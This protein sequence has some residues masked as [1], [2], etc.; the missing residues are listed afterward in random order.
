MNRT[1]LALALVTV[2][3][4]A[5]AEVED[6]LLRIDGA[7]VRVRRAQGWEAIALAERESRALGAAGGVLP[8]YKGE[9][10]GWRIVAATDGTRS[11]ALQ[12]RG[13]GAGT[14]VLLS[15]VDLAPPRVPARPALW[16][17]PGAR[18]LR[19]VEQDGP[20]PSRQWTAHSLWQPTSMLS[21]L[22]FAAHAA[23]WHVELR[24]EVQ[25]SLRKEDQRLQVVVLPDPSGRQG[26]AV[27]MTHWGAQ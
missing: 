12:V 18:V 8:P 2:V 1:T 11:R 5:Q 10:G 24:D 13:E 25:L 16:L 7:P 21:W 3:S 20:A 4:Q 15:E 17:P 9:V 23:Q 19:T 6:I 27:V 26:S 22:T 14:E